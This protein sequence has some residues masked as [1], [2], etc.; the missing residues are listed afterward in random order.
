M[1]IPGHLGLT[2]AGLAAAGYLADAML[3]R[4]QAGPATPPRGLARL[5]NPL[6]NLPRSVRQLRLDLRLFFLG[7]LLPDILDKPV[8]FW[9]APDLVNANTRNLGHTLVFNAALLATAVLLLRLRGST[10]W[11]ALAL[12]SIAHLLLDLM[13]E[14]PVIFLWPFLGWQFPQGPTTLQEYLLFHYARLTSSPEEAAGLLVLA[15]FA[16]LLVWRKAV[17]RFLNTGLTE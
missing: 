16:V 9:L 8:A 4:P 5:I 15:W 2:L 17:R 12:G 11:L 6:L 1:N 14:S 13:W 3:R 10:G 7:A